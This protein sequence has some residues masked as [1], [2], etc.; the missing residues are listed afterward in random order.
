MKNIKRL[1]LLLAPFLVLFVMLLLT[2]PFQLPLMLLMVPF[3]LFGLGCFL[4]IREL[5][6][7]IPVSVR[8]R[9]VIAGVLTSVLLLAMLLQSIRQLSLKDLLILSALLIGVTFY[10]RR[11]DI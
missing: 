3:L 4:V 11:I 1:A 7:L 8:R 5:L 9:K 2:D 6:K 10:V